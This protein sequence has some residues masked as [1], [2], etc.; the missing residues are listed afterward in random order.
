MW[1]QN[2]Q[3]S[4]YL[5][6]YHLYKNQRYGTTWGIYFLAQLFK[7]AFDPE[8]W[9]MRNVVNE[10][11]WIFVSQYVKTRSMIDLK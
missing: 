1:K 11:Q 9:P 7:L 3:I 2:L 10:A 8:L 6:L 5:Y 4:L